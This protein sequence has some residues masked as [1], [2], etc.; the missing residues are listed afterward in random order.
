MNDLEYMKQLFNK[1][2]HEVLGIEAF[3][4]NANYERK[5]HI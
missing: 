4:N 1:Y 5:N 3:A 2:Q